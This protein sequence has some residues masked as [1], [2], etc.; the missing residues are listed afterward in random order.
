MIK[1]Y[2]GSPGCGKT[3]HIMYSVRKQMKEIKKYDKLPKFLKIFRSVPKQNYYTNVRSCDFPYYPTDQ[4]GKTVLPG[5]TVYYLDEAG[6]EYNNRKYKSLSQEAI[7]YFK[8]HRH[9]KH[10]IFVY[11]QSWEDMDIT[12]R[13]LADELYVLKRIGPFTMIRRIRKFFD[14]DKDTH[15]PIDGYRFIGIF[16]SLLPK[17]FGGIKSIQFI[18]RP[19]Y[20]K[21]FNSYS[22]DNPL[23]LY[24]TP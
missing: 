3:T 22:I 18:F 1:I 5:D 2:F 24:Q 23:P 14:I 20:Y 8:L 13:R 21:Y 10:D 16:W 12:L 17:C 11:S 7:S 4:I 15:Q 19:F 9:Y 6:I